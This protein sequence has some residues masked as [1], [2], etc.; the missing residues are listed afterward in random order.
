MKIKTNE[1]IGHA[2]DW[3]VA[4]GRASEGKWP[5]NWKNVTRKTISDLPDTKEQP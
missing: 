4:Y 1:L 3:V 5:K 2:L